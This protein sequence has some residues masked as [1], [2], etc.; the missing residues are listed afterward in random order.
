MSDECELKRAAGAGVHPCD[1]ESCA[2]WHVVEHL[3][4][5]TGARTGCAIQHFS[6]LEGGEQVTAWLHSLKQR[7]EER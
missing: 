2:F 6:L 1:H 7:L 3:D 4:V 5:E